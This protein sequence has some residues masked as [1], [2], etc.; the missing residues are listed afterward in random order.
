MV[1]AKGTDTTYTKFDGDRE[2]VT[3]CLL[4]NLSTAGD[5]WEV[6]IAGL[7]QA[8]GTRNGLEQFLGESAHHVSLKSWEE[9]RWDC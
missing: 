6:D 7:G 8:L 2:E 1:N 3:A 5:A 4:G 9:P